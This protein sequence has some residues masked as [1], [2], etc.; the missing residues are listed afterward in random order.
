MTRILA[1]TQPVQVGITVPVVLDSK[2]IPSPSVVL[3][4][5]PVAV[6]FSQPVI[7]HTLQVEVVAATTH[8]V[9]TLAL[10]ITVLLAAAN[11]TALDVQKPFLAMS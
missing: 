1:V 11:V 5:T 7:R 2:K 4:Q 3:T 10:V 8:S 6:G 9:A